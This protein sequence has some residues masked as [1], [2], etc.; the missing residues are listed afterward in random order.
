MIE[1]LLSYRIARFALTG[2]IATMTHICVAF[3]LIH[4]SSAGVFVANL[5]GFACAFSLS[6]LMQSLFV[7]K[8]PLSF[9]NITRFFIVQFS[10]LLISQ[11]ISELFSGTNSYL[12]VLIVV[13]LIPLVTYAIHRAWT[14]RENSKEDQKQ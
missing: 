13:F 3:A 7:F 11:L 10:A 1:K 12:N 14:Y 6:Y 8:K 5:L 4:F 9:Q 2:G